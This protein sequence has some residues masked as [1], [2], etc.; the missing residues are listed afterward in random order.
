MEA[1]WA[2]SVI[3]NGEFFGMQ[4][5]EDNKG[6]EPVRWKMMVFWMVPSGFLKQRARHIGCE[7]GRTRNCPTSACRSMSSASAASASPQK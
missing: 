1:T 7:L 3:L 4:V 2:R 5:A 6:N